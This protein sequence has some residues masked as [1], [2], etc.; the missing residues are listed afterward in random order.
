MKNKLIEYIDQHKEETI[1]LGRKL[2]STPE[3]G[4]KEFKTVELLKEA[5][6]IE[7]VEPYAKTGFKVTLGKGKPHI[8][9]IAELDAI[10]TLGHPYA[11]L[12]DQS[13][14]HSCGHSSQ[15]AI[16]VAAFKALKELN[17]KGTISLFFTPAEEYTDLEYRRS[18]IEQG[19]IQYF[20]G[21]IQ[22]L[23]EGAFEGVDCFIHLH[24]SGSHRYY[25]STETKLAGFIYK[26]FVFKG[27]ASH[28]AVLPHAGINALNACNLFLTATAMLRETF[29][30]EDHNRF[31]GLITEGGQTINS[32]PERVVYESYVRSF[33]TD[34]LQSLSN[35][36]TNTAKHCAQALNGDCEVIDEFGY[37]P[38]EPDHN[39]AQVIEKNMLQF[40]ASDQIRRES[41]SIAAGDIGDLSLFYPTVQF[42]YGGIS[43]TI[44]GKDMAISDEERVYIESSKVVALSVYDLLNDETLVNH[45]KKNFKEKMT[46]EDYFKSR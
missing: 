45:I 36:L 4:Y 30:E 15:C 11:N 18:L 41:E 21:K 16:M 23:H 12:E 32:I 19:E 33:N 13:A 8:G 1:E 39:L 22:M 10:P 38:F 34:R 6:G 2:F 46:K 42:G 28:A 40:V 31:H 9:L 7:T 17:L 5:L 25:F 26:K 29:K 3:L 37:Y 44:H 35:Q 43:G 24:A 27:K 14:A 20:G